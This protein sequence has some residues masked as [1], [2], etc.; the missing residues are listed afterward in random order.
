MTLGLRKGIILGTVGGVF[1]LANAVIITGWLQNHGWIDWANGF[2]EEFLTGTAITII[3]TLL[4]LLVP[5]RENTHSWFG[6][7][8]TCNHLLLSKGKYCPECGGRV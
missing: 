8:P 5:G 2:R 6:R 3:V 7:C 4:I 1:L